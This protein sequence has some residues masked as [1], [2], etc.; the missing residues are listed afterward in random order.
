MDQLRLRM[1]VLR[2]VARQPARADR[3]LL[4]Q[5]QINGHLRREAADPRASLERL[6]NAIDDETWDGGR[7][8]PDPGL[9]SVVSRQ[10]AE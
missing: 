8:E 6:A 1:N 2:L 7:L 5:R 9:R 3:Q 10:A 4:L